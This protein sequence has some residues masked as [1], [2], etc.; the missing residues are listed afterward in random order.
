MR[1]ME[2]IRQ[3]I[4]VPPIQNKSLNDKLFG[5]FS[6]IGL[7]LGLVLYTVTLGII[8]GFITFTYWGVLKILATF[9]KLKNKQSNTSEAATNNSE[10]D[11]II[12]QGG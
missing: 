3:I 12:N 9:R 4:G 6:S 2:E 11:I 8:F 5:W 7:I 10:S 1:S